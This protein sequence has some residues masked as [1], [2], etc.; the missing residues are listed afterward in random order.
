MV[1]ESKILCLQGS[2]SV[3][4]VEFVSEMSLDGEYLI[5]VTIADLQRSIM[6]SHKLFYHNLESALICL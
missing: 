4:F 5:I 1:S 3:L 6:L 2:H